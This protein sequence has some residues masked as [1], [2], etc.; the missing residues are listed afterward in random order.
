MI[1]LRRRLNEFDGF[2]IFK[3]FKVLPG[4]L[5]KNTFI[6]VALSLLATIIDLLGVASIMPFV[7]LVQLSEISDNKLVRF[8]FGLMGDV[9]LR[10]F[11]IIFA[12]M[13]LVLISG[14]VMLKASLV[15]YQYKISHNIEAYL[16]SLLFRKYLGYDFAWFKN[17]HTSSLSKNILN[18]VSF[19]IAESF[20]PLLKFITDSI[21]VFFLSTFLIAVNWKVTLIMFGIFMSA[22]TIIYGFSRAKIARYGKLRLRLNE[23][24][25]RTLEEYISVIRDIKIFQNESF[26]V[27]EF[28]SVAY[29]YSSAHAVSK[30]LTFLP[31]FFMEGLVFITVVIGLLGFVIYDVDMVSYIPLVTLYLMAM[32]KLLPS[33]Q[34]MIISSAKLKNS[35]PSVTELY[36]VLESTPSLIGEE[37]VLQYGSLSDLKLKG[38]VFAFNDE[39]PLF[40]HLNIDLGNQGF[41][42]VLGPSGAGKSTFLEIISGITKQRE[43]L[44]LYNGTSVDRLYRVTRLA[45]VS[46]DI[47]VLDTSFYENVA[48]GMPSAR[49]DKSKVEKICKRLQ[50]DSWIVESFEEG[51]NTNIGQNG[52][53]ISGGQKQRLGLARALY[54]DPEILVL[55]EGTSALNVSLEAAVLELIRELSKDILVLCSS[56]SLEILK[57]ADR[58]LYINEGVLEEFSSVDKFQSSKSYKDYV[59]TTS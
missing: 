21:F 54:T 23:R 34:Q 8:V 47:V 22:Y 55:D 17:N 7:E 35:L 51:Y 41:I 9:S 53:R 25:F 46:Q 27:D 43:G 18:E 58:T 39:K 36:N 12:F 15:H 13:C 14:G 56:H 49:I 28:R 2:M 20:L 38:V 19:V 4:G 16:S 29:E 48:F 5:Q 37:T 6:V 44:V 1:L 52:S 31:K 30:T 10:Q 50:L 24:R 40:E 26:Y 33:V 57:Y 45:Y 42:A 59:S 32:Y 3:I 11:K